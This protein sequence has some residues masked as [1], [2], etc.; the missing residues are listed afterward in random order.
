MFTT[1]RHRLRGAESCAAV[2]TSGA[3][4]PMPPDSSLDRKFSGIGRAAGAERDRATIWKL[5]VASGAETI[6]EPGGNREHHDHRPAWG[7]SK[8]A[9]QVRFIVRAYTCHLVSRWT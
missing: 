9:R 1:C 8:S 2:G 4:A 3:S 5:P 7:R 6:G